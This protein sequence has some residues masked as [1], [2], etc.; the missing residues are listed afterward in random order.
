VAIHKCRR[1]VAP[2]CA[3]VHECGGSIVAGSVILSILGDLK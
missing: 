1:L 2:R 3:P